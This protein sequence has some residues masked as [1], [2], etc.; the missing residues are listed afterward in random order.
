M[1]QAN[2]VL[3]IT[4]TPGKEPGVQRDLKELLKIKIHRLV[5][6]GTINESCQDIHVKISGDG[7]QVGHNNNFI[8]ITCTVLNDHNTANSPNGH[9]PIAII[10]A[11]EKYEIMKEHLV[12]LTKVISSFTQYVYN[13]VKYNII[14]YP[15]SDY[16]FLLCTL[17]LASANSNYPCIKCKMIKSNF[18]NPS[19]Q[20]EPR[21]MEG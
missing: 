9:E 1:Q 21:T 4:R 17:G 11:E 7:T 2:T 15:G 20:G 10:A 12:D 8:N 3:Q 19:L 5:D 16:N 14:Y 18:F 13:D 6:N